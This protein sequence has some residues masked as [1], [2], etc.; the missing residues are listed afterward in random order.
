MLDFLDN[1]SVESQVRQ[2]IQ[3]SETTDIAL[4]RNVGDRLKKFY[5][6]SENLDNMISAFCH[7]IDEALKE[8]IMSVSWWGMIIKTNRILYLEPA[9]DIYESVRCKND[10]L[11]NAIANFHHNKLHVL[12]SQLNSKVTT[13]S[14]DYE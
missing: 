8:K 2:L 1:E 3:M 11:S 7:I 9:A 4:I 12:G 14:Q 13:I 6:L 10:R 5:S